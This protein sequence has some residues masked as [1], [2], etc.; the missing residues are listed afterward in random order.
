MQDEILRFL[1]RSHVEPNESMRGWIKR[2]GLG[3]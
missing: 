2:M 3:G 1:C